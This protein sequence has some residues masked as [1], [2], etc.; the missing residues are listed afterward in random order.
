MKGNMFDNLTVEWLPERDTRCEAFLGS[1][2]TSNVDDGPLCPANAEVLITYISG[3]TQANCHHHYI[4]RTADPNRE[5][6][7]KKGGD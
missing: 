1:G 2:E 7:F 5:I 6:L 4:T 3:T